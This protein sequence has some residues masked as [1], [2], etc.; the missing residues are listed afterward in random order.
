MP[1]G[2]TQVSIFEN[3]KVPVL[4]IRWLKP[5]SLLLTCVKT[6]W[7]IIKS[8]NNY[9]IVRPEWGKTPYMGQIFKVLRVATPLWGKC[10]VATHTP[11]NGTWESSG[12]PKTQNT[13]SWVKTPCIEMFLYTVGKVLKC[14]CPKCHRMNHLDICSTSYGWKEGRESNWQ[15]DFRPLK[16]GNP[17]SDACR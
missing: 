4:M 16:V 15:F 1:L 11:E 9:L 10:E 6:K 5:W 2:I 14:R 13:I 8:K 12:F 3:L 17:D 7:M